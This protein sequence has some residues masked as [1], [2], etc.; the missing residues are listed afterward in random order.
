MLSKKRRSKD[1]WNGVSR[2]IDH[3]ADR[4]HA[5]SDL[6][7]KHT[8]Q[9]QTIQGSHSPS[10]GEFRQIG[11]TASTRILKKPDQESSLSQEGSGLNKMRRG[12]QTISKTTIN[13]SRRG[14]RPLLQKGAECVRSSQG[15]I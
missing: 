15:G 2:T 4:S 13:S 7:R 10:E 5:Q 11:R 1:A 14:K 8:K 9:L 3:D 12:V 6:A